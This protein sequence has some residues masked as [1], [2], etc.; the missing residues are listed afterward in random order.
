MMP[1]ARVFVIS[2]FR[3]QKQPM[4]YGSTALSFKTV[5]AKKFNK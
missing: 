1:A 5:L 4:N 2:A 3:L